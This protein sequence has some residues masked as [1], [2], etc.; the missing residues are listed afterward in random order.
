[1]DL[2]ELQVMKHGDHP[3]TAAEVLH[4]YKEDLLPEFVGRRLD[5][6]NQVGNFGDYPI[7]VAAIRGAVDE[8]NALIDAGADVN[9]IGE[10]RM[11]PLHEAVGQER[12]E[13]VKLLLARGARLTDKNEWGETALDIARRHKRDDLIELLEGAS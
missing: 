12:V 13:A 7:H 1:M 3:L 9:A 11:T 4:R 10:Q 2:E 8:L 5:D 6:V